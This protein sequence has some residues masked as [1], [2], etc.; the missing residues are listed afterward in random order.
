[1]PSSLW[2]AAQWASPC[3]LPPSGP[4]T[5]AEIRHLLLMLQ[6][7]RQKGFQAWETLVQMSDEDRK[8]DDTAQ[9]S[10]AQGTPPRRSGCLSQRGVTVRATTDPAPVDVGEHP[11]Q[12]PRKSTA[13]PLAATTSPA[14]RFA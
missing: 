5:S 8:G 7:E 6:R 4:M 10:S 1:M 3:G 11:L 2:A 9:G 13:A 14:R 12:S